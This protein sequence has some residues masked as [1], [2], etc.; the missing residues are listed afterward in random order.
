MPTFLNGDSGL[1]IRQ[2]LNEVLEHISDEAGAGVEL[3]FNISIDVDGNVKSSSLSG[4]G[5]RM[6][7][8]DADGQLDTQEI[9]SGGGGDYLP[10]SGGTI[11][12]NIV[13]SGEGVGIFFNTFGSPD[14]FITTG[15]AYGTNR[16]EVYSDNGISF[17]GDGNDNG[18]AWQFINEGATYGGV[19]LAIDMQTGDIDAAGNFTTSGN[20]KFQGNGADTWLPY[21]DDRNYLTSPVGTRIRNGGAAG[22]AS[23]ADFDPTQISFYMPT[24][25]PGGTKISDD[26]DVY[27]RR[28]S[29]TTGVYYFVD[30]G[31]KYLYFDGSTYNFGGTYGVNM[32]GLLGASQI[33]LNSTA[34]QIKIHNSGTLIGQI[35]ATDTTWLRINQDVAKNIYTPRYIRA[36]GGFFVDGT[37]FGINGSGNFRVSR[38]IY[39][40]SDTA[41]YIDFGVAED[42]IRVVTSD[43][44]RMR[45]NASGTTIYGNA[46]QTGSLIYGNSDRN[47]SP[48]GT[49]NSTLTQQIWSMG[50]AYRSHASGTNFGNLYGAAY[51]HT[52]NTTGGTM[53]GGHQLVWC[54]NG[55]GTAAIG[56][57]IWTSGNVTAYSDIRVKTNLEII[58]DA[59]D[60]IHKING[61]TFDRTD[62]QID[63]EGNPTVPV[64]QAGVVA[65]EVLEILP[66]V[67]M[68]GPTEDD[69]EGHYS[70]DYSRLT[71]LLIEGVKE[72]QKQI[73]ELKAMIMEMKNDQ[74]D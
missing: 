27:A 64:R 53:A 36:D 25:F 14:A 21:S 2:K 39:E 70:V 19:K 68:G 8:A 37:S 29:G 4:T 34:D 17:V 65:Q 56:S 69:P 73:N 20:A 23:I 72:Q 38:Y 6:V 33:S 44:E 11:T 13:T 61:Y 51:K 59:L 18:G 3:T 10:L 30:G 49:Y 26:G 42:S 54:Q 62:V 1:E 35:E 71:A 7:V 22:G 66:E 43:T 24:V 48:M 63:N 55:G 9:P 15:D 16:L 32:G 47:D 67:V 58:P 40:G 60:K 46:Y 45:W 12:G 31:Q 57:N 28:S 50:A 74:V 52:N 5:I 41:N